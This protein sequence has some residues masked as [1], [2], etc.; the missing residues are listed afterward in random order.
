M[1]HAMN[2][3]TACFLRTIE[4]DDVPMRVI[5]GGGELYWAVYGVC[6]AI[7]VVM[8]WRM[9]VQMWRLKS[10]NNQTKK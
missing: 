10:D 8:L 5:L 2:N 1:L 6:V 4:L 9:T 3:L 7:A